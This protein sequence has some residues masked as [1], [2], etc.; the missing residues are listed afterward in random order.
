MEAVGI[1]AADGQHAEA[2]NGHQH[3][4]FYVGGE[5]AEQHVEFFRLQAAAQRFAPRHEFGEGRPAAL[6][7]SSRRT[8]SVWKSSAR[9]ATTRPQLSPSEVARIRERV[10]VCTRTMSCSFSWAISTRSCR[11]RVR[12]R[13]LSR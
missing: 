12:S 8:K 13:F 7:N 4:G 11:R 1:V 6:R 5:R 2:G 10:R 3:G 9:L